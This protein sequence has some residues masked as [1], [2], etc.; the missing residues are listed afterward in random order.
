MKQPSVFL[1]A[2]MLWLA[3]AAPSLGAP[4]PQPPIDP[5]VPPA[6]LPAGDDG[7][8]V[9]AVHAL[10]AADLAAWLDG[11]VPYALKSGEI[12]GLV[13]SVVKDGKVL[14]QKG[15]GMADVEAAIPM[16]P[17]NSLVRPGSTS[18]LFTWTAVMQLVQQGKID[19]DRS[20]NDYLDFKID[21]SYEPVTM[22][23]LMNHRA[24]FEEGI[25]D[26]LGYDPAQAQTTERYLKEHPRPM[27]FAPGA[28]PA[29]SNYGVALAGYIVQ[30]VSGE[31]FENYVERHIFRPL[32]MSHST[33]VQP[34]PKDFP[35]QLSKGYRTTGE[36]P[37]AFELVIT[38]P[39]GALTTTAA[40]MGRFMLAHLQQGGLDGNR[41]L[42]AATVA[43][44]HSPSEPARPGFGVMA[45]G[46][47]RA[48]QNG[49]EVIGHGGDTI[50]H[51]TELDLLPGEG[52]GIFFSFNSRGKDGAVY[53]ARKELFDGFMDRYFPAA[54]VSEPPTL[55]SAAADA[56]RIA[57][58]YQSSRRVEHGFLSLLYLLQQTAITA[59]PD[60]TIS[61]PEAT[62]A[63]ATYREVGPQL[64][65]KVGGT[66]TLALTEVDGVKTV[67]DSENPVSVL[68]EGPLAR[69]A[70]LN[71][72]VLVFSAAT[73]L[74][75][76]LAWPL[77]ALLRR[78]DRATS[79]AGPG[80]RKLRTL[81]RAAVVV[82]VL[83][84]GAWFMLIKP[85]LNTD[86][87]V[88]RTSI[89]WVVGLLEVSGL[90]AVGAA[91]AGVW[92]AWRMARTDATR[93][94]RAWAVLVAL[95]LLGVVWIGVV[96]RLMT[97]NLNY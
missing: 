85:L 9:G 43:R 19:L 69:S 78:A 12:A 89:D 36:P 47:F 5:Q 71:L 42:D 33:F 40:D 91:A 1:A 17:A 25:K 37:S 76:L 52:V 46:F 23:H 14:L 31:S 51:H 13:I 10:D 28:V 88:Y 70:A 96:G 87:G 20:V 80:L 92:V 3:L 68:Q 8:A 81:Q 94:T 95:A 90:L 26:L 21:E 11:R 7:A 72:G 67:I 83:Y 63:M 39:A 29:Y 24:G 61:T 57:G 49:R 65:R 48:T 44:M 97:W 66:Q 58:S 18:K 45:H 64:W 54:A 32:G 75:A 41:I 2:A 56:R 59:N 73:L 60:G 55:A 53:G 34:L 30:R 4:A 86:V 50:V 16:D 35:G 74:C 62:G 22:R 77:G 84:L 82:D 79:G 38:A 27:L 93:L 6:P 15:Y